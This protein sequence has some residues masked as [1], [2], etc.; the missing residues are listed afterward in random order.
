MTE[1]VWTIPATRM[2]AGHEHRCRCRRRRWRSSNDRRRCARATISFPAPSRV[3][4]VEHRRAD[5]G[6]RET[7]AQR[8]DHRTRVSFSISRLG[9]RAD[10]FPREIAEASLAHSIGDATE[11]AYQRGDFIAKRRQVMD[12][13]ARYCA[14]PASKA[15][16]VIDMARRT[17]KTP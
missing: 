1:R 3:S 4:R 7:R 14:A 11:R 9:G 8:R 13:W 12:A 16:E 2:K 15:A 6:H 10:N 17:V 5:G